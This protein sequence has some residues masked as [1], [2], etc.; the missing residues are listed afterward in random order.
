M[1]PRVAITGV[2]VVAPNAWTPQQLWLQAAAGR[3]PA[4]LL[5][6]Y[7]GLAL[8]PVDGSLNEFARTLR[9][10]HRADRVVRLALSAAWRAWNGAGLPEDACD[11]SRLGVVVGSSR[12]PVGKWEEATAYLSPQG[13]Q[14]RTR[15]SLAA[16]SMMGAL[17]GSLA[18]SLGI[19]GPAFTVST[20]CASG[21]H[22]LALAACQIAGGMADIIVAGGADSP[23]NRCMIRQ[24]HATGILDP[25]LPP[26][27]VCRP[28]DRSAAGTVLGEA[29]AFLV[30][31]SEASACRRGAAILGWLS[32]WGMA[33]DGNS[34]S[35]ESAG[36]DALEASASVALAQ[37]GVNLSDI[38][39]LNT[40]GTG[41]RI[42]DLIEMR[43]ISRLDSRLSK[44]I[45]FGSTKAVT[46]HCL[47]ATPVLEAAICLE[48]LRRGRIPPSA[49]CFDPHPE[50][51]AGLVRQEVPLKADHVMSVSLG[52]W[53][54]A[55][56]L[57]IN[58]HRDAKAQ[59]SS[60]LHGID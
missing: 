2:G 54:G 46:G 24:F 47:G 55:C 1:R 12:G 35:A 37:A 27:P 42:N 13:K 33:M 25:A 5:E 43:W 29:A 31:E 22:A 58:R 4:R 19:R 28:Y 26:S 41:T 53:G 40:H 34:S 6:E 52:F 51:P 50:A 3:S 7:P 59:P 14:I 18:A 39:Y 16:D 44:P 8:C 21:G 10:A 32:G 30:L 45:R 60:C 56:S 38:G 48:T 15:P 17:H 49:H 9:R 20:A 11:P 57:V 23:L 36:A